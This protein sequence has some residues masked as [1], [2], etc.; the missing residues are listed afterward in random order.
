MI[1]KIV[2][3]RKRL[4]ITQKE[5]AKS[6]GWG[7]SR[8]KKFEKGE[9]IQMSADDFFSVLKIFGMQTILI[10]ATNII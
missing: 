3:T 6:M 8:Y 1:K 4:K 7:L 9:V 10:D 2:E 5:M